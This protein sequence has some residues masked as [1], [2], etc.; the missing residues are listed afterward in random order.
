MSGQDAMDES[1]GGREGAP[2]RVL[3]AAA[4]ATLRFTDEGL[5]PVIAQDRTSG[6]VLVLAW[7][8]REALERTL[9]TGDLHFWSRSRRSLW[10][11]GETSG[12][13]LTEA[14]LRADCDGDAVL[15]RVTPT[16]PAC[17]TGAATCFG[18][19]EVGPARADILARLGKVLDE[20]ARERP[21]GSYTVRLLEDRNLMVK[22]LGEE[23][24]EM[25]A[26]L[27]ADDPLAVVEE[28]ADLIYHAMVAVVG[29][30]RH[31][32]DVEA[33]LERRSGG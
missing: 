24:A 8:N 6:A 19:A 17:H 7:A 30:G 9:A 25:V 23:S 3:D 1:A 22:K 29:A 31:W 32:E 12:N 15:A 33:E 2:G 18:N 20:R 14:E 10:R 16:G 5:V 13:V 26:A 27:A 4:L 11:K 21:P 28:A